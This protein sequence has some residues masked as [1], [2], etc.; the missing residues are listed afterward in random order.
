L[1]HYA[2]GDSIVF[3]SDNGR[4]NIAYSIKNNAYRKLAALAGGH[5]TIEAYCVNFKNEAIFTFFVDT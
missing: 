4:Y 2:G 1:P 3:I 5:G